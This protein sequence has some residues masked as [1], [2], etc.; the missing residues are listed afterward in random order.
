MSRVK[1]NKRLLENLKV[2]RVCVG[3]HYTAIML[4]N[5]Y[6]GFCYTPMEDLGTTP[7]PPDRGF[8]RADVFDLLE[9]ADSLDLIERCVGIATLNAMCQYLMDLKGYEREFVDIVE[10]ARIR[11]N[12]LVAIVGYM[13]P[14]VRRV[15]EKS[16]KVVVLER[17]VK[18]RKEKV[19]PDTFADLVL[20]K[21]E[22]VFITGSSLVNGT[23]DIL[24]TLC[25]RARSVAVVGP[26]A[27]SL[28]E[29]FFRRGVHILGGIYAK[30]V[31]PLEA[32]AEGKSLKEM[33]GITKKYVMRLLQKTN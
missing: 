10:T 8:H 29:P 28:P 19:L 17:N 3:I 26:T 5:G 25:K 6:V 12:D 7:A 31:E 20:P 24:L 15:E 33:G 11:K 21:A 2:S 9:L 16:E 1:K 30:G 32:V 13:E 23:L 18:L 22:I 14:I 27:S 4:Q